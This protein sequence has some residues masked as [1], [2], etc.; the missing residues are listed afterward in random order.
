M[1]LWCISTQQHIN[2][3]GVVILIWI[4]F[5]LIWLLWLFDDFDFDDCWFWWFFALILNLIWSD[6]S[7]LYCV[8]AC[9]RILNGSK[10]TSWATVQPACHLPLHDMIPLRLST[11]L[12]ETEHQLAKSYASIVLSVSGKSRCTEKITPISTCYVPLHLLRV[13]SVLNT[14]YIDFF[15][16]GIFDHW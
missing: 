6:C 2:D 10:T 3:C 5:D 4:D 9:H 11:S 12:A 15:L 14:F 7:E 16:L 13:C 8:G 1:N